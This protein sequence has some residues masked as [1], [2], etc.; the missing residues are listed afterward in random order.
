[1]ILEIPCLLVTEWSWGQLVFAALKAARPKKAGLPVACLSVESVA[2]GCRGLGC[3]PACPGM[4]KFQVWE[5]SIVSQ[6]RNRGWI[7]PSGQSSGGLWVIF[8]PSNSD[9]VRAQE[10]ILTIECLDYKAQV[11]LNYQYFGCQF[12]N[13]VKHWY[14]VYCFCFCFCF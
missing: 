1:M 4:R 13:L 3:P 7:Q 9:Q 12:Q 14:G 5:A 11:E 10:C 6:T 2:D 8:Y